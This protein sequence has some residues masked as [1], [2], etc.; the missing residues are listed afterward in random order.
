MSRSRWCK[1]CEGWHDLA[2]VWPEACAGHF[3]SQEA[4]P[5]IVSD[6]TAPFRSMADGKMYDSKSRYRQ[7]LR[8]RGLV[9]VGNEKITQRRVEAPPV[10]AQLQRAFQQLSSR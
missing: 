8:D 2:E 9:E 5:Q 1:V 10:R 7:T 6:T 3:A 4:G